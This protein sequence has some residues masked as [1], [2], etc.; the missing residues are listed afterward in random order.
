MRTLF[1]LVFHLHQVPVLEILEIKDK[2]SMN[3]IMSLQVNW[4]KKKHPFL[5]SA[6]KFAEKKPFQKEFSIAFFQDGITKE[7]VMALTSEVKTCSSQILRCVQ[8]LRRK[9]CL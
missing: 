8:I 7:D 4:L 5:E 2:L 3:E 9:C 6:G 1:D